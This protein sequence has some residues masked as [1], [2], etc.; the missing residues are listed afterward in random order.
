MRLSELK[1][2][3]WSQLALSLCEPLG[4]LMTWP[5]MEDLLWLLAEAPADD[6][7][8]TQALDALRVERAREIGQLKRLLTDDEAF[9]ADVTWLARILRH[10][11]A[12]QVV[13]AMVS[14]GSG[15][16]RLLLQQTLEQCDQ[17]AVRQRERDA[18][19]HRLEKGLRQLLGL[20]QEQEIMAVNYPGR[21]RVT[22]DLMHRLNAEKEDSHE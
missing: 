17:I 18:V 8:L 9:D 22:R 21:A 14:L 6:P 16:S 3:D 20:P 11:S 19:L 7:A 5:G 2:T 1:G 12:S 13:R 15:C 10:H 4:S